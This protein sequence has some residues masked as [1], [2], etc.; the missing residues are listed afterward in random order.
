MQET[1]V[2]RKVKVNCGFIQII[3]MGHQLATRIPLML[4]SARVRTI[5]SSP[6]LC[7]F[8]LRGREN[9]KKSLSSRERALL[10]CLQ[11][12]TVT[13][14]NPTDG[15]HSI[16]QDDCRKVTCY[17]LDDHFPRK[18]PQNEMV[19]TWSPISTEGRMDAA[20]DTNEWVNERERERNALNHGRATTPPRKN[21]TNVTAAAGSTHI[22]LSTGRRCQLVGSSF[23]RIA[24][25]M[26]RE[27]AILIRIETLEAFYNTSLARPRPL[28]L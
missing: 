9:W 4:I 21:S 20:A 24:W 23:V 7:F 16:M 25:I 10:Q 15:E 8:V 18:K 2:Y 26:I 27:Y 3:F 11:H 13:L 19:S 12:H 17:S 28:G 1:Q 14:L 6:S 5:L 22:A